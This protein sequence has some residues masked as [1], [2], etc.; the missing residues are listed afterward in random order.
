MRNF[1]WRSEVRA[2]GDGVVHVFPQTAEDVIR[3][4]KLYRPGALF[5]LLKRR[6]S[7]Q[8]WRLPK[9]RQ[10]NLE[11]LEPRVLLSESATAQINLVSTTGTST[12]PIYHYDITVTDTGTT[13]VGTFWFG[14]IPDEDF[15]PSVPSAVSNPTGWNN[16][17]TGSHNSSDGTA[18]EWVASSNAIT[19]GQSLSGFDFTTTDSPSVLGAVSPSHPAYPAT[20]SFVYSG[21]A[22][23][24]AGFQF[25]ASPPVQTTASTTTVSSSSPS[26]TAGTSVILSATV[27]SVSGG[28]TPTGSVSFTENGN[29][30][31]TGTLNSNGVGSLTTSVLPI[32]ADQI[33]ATYGGDSAYNGSSSSPFTQT[34]TTPANAIATTTT[35]QSSSPSATASQSI[36]FTATITPSSSGGAAPTG[37]VTF[38][39]N[40]GSLG[41]SLLQ[42]NGT[43]TFTANALPSGS[44]TIVATY[45]GD[46]TYASSSSQPFA[47]SIE[48]PSANVP[49]IAKSTLP[50]AVVAGLAANGVVTVDLAND[51]SATSKAK[52]T[53]D[54]FASTTGTID[55]SSIELAQMS[56]F[57][58]LTTTRPAALAIPV[59]IKAGELPSGSF[60]LFAQAIDPSGDKS[61]SAAGPALNAA[62]PF[63][64]L[65]ETVVKSTLAASSASNTKAHGT[66]TLNVVN[67]GNITTTGSTTIALEASASG[68]LDSSAV[69]I[70]SASLP[71]RIH[72]GKSAHAAVT[73]KQLPQLTVGTNTIFAKVTD[74]DGN[75]TSVM[76]GTMTITA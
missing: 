8:N 41:A 69:Q 68:A 29:F 51:T 75:V 32:G 43:A 57:I 60:M 26:A 63:I 73:L 31:G 67:G 10:V 44:D 55:S 33:V 2:V 40:G 53:V 12:A 58:V 47:Q 48:T 13:N 76:V 1:F 71:L 23:S 66:V 35:L 62:A 59:H 15:L 28:A 11:A 52:T 39:V 36:T 46:G 50:A 49:T 9:K 18:I 45:G 20:T 4:D 64:A 38:T 37:M 16:T 7:N 65:S 30:L 61:N 70:A 21:A 56:R 22:F 14:W 5:A 17:L 19:P 27:A 34:I 25:V 24:D 72:P 74:A 3:I 54:V 42:S 6:N